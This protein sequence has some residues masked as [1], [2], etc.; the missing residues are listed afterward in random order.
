[1]IVVAPTYY[2]VL[3]HKRFIIALSDLDKVSIT[4]CANWLYVS[5]DPDTKE[6]H[7]TEHFAAGEQFVGDHVDAIEAEEEEP[8]EQFVPPHQKP[9]QQEEGSSSW[10]T[11]Q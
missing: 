5:V 1:M 11:D 9:T 7:E 10:S 6:G 2:F 8:Q 4:D 3:I